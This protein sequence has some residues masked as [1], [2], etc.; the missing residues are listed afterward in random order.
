MTINVIT[1]YRTTQY[2][3]ATGS[4][5]VI[6]I[7]GVVFSN[8]YGDSIVGPGGRVDVLGAVAASNYGV[9]FNDSGYDG[10]VYVGV[11]ASISSGLA[12]IH[13]SGALYLEN[14]GT[15]N[16]L[17]GIAV[18]SN[19]YTR[20][21]NDGAISGISIFDANPNDTCSVDNFSYLSGG[22]YETLNDDIAYEGYGESDIFTNS[23]TVSGQVFL[24][25]GASSILN[26]TGAING[27]IQAAAGA[28][29]ND[30]GTINGV[31]TLSSGVVNLNN[32]KSPFPAPA[33]PSISSPAPATSSI[34][35]VTR[36][37]TTFSAPT[38][39]STSATRSPGS[40]AASIRSTL[41]RTRPTP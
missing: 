27:A 10:V 2:T 31:V 40:S 22:T 33:T 21:K 41:R 1:S 3:L 32:A 26:N 38:P 6:V 35:R 7:Q 19:G 16:S 25:T 29:I 18:S 4:D 28:T 8:T 30:S 12:A 36:R 5:G 24:G 20:I 37:G 34:C 39:P 23:G 9:N 13:A 11:G 15:I 17:N 14:H